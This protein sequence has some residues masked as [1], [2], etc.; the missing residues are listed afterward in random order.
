MNGATSVYRSMRR[1]ADL[2]HTPENELYATIAVNDHK[3]HM[4]LGCRTFKCWLSR[5]F[6]QSTGKVPS[7]QAVQAAIMTLKGDAQFEGDQHDV[8]VRV[9]HA[10]GKLYLDLADDTCRAVEVDASG[11]RV[12]QDP[13]VRFRRARGMLPLPV[14]EEGG[15]L[16]LLRHYVNVNDGG[17]LLLRAWLI[18]A[19]RPSGP[20]P[21][22][23]VQGETGSG[24]SMMCWLLKALVDPNVVPLRNLPKDGRDLMIAARN[25]WL[26]VYDH[27]SKPKVRRLNTVCRNAGR[28]I[29][30]NG[31]DALAVQPDVRDRSA[32]IFLPRISEEKRRTERDLLVAFGADRPKILGGLLD[33]IVEKALL[34]GETT[35]AERTT[36]ER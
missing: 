24:K 4:P 8:H 33:L 17:W 1:Q 7:N 14:P 32:I 26:L 6:Y 27:I 34:A 25:G 31:I 22:L 5:Q 2:W 21:V 18:D 29:I 16:D 12:I 28:P 20:Y 30:V 19:L 10:D 15:S 11:W 35:K 36:N 9:A 3:E 13:P 23:V